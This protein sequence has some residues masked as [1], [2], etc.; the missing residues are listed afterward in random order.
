MDE[1]KAKGKKNMYR[2][3]MVDSKARRKQQQQKKLLIT[4]L[5]IRCYQR[6][7]SCYNPYT[8]VGCVM[9]N[10]ANDNEI[11]TLT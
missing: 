2:Y 8:Y 1:T 7:C 6:F 3:G 4:T 10:A 11:Y 5:S 9:M